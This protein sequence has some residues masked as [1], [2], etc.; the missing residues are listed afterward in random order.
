MVSLARYT[1]ERIREWNDFVAASRNGTFLFDRRYMDYHSDRYCD[2]SLMFRDDKGKLIAVLPANISDGVLYSHQ[3]LTY[4]GLL[5]S[6]RLTAVTVLEIFEAMNVWLASQGV[7]KVVYKCIPHIF[8]RYPAEEDLYALFKV[9]GATLTIRNIST[10]IDLSAPMKWSRIR[11]FGADKALKA[12]IKV[13]E[14]EDYDT[15]WTILDANLRTTHHVKPVHTA[16]E[17]KLLHS[18]FPDKIRLFVAMKGND[19]LGGVLVYDCYP[20]LH[21]QYISASEEGKQLH[22]LD[23]VFL[24][25]LKS[26]EFADFRYVDFGNSNEQRGRYLNESLIYQKEGFG[27]RAVCYDTYEWEITLC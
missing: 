25:L 8:H 4:G 19:I 13:C 24:H 11:S 2:C 15:F 12:G 6:Q 17:L 1:Y 21:T 7:H 9:C 20:T 10:T 23:L 16:E 26:R 14:S 22:A 27:G 3:G 5:L 18:R